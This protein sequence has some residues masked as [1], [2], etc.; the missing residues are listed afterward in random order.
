TLMLYS[1]KVTR[2]EPGIRLA[3]DIH[4]LAHQGRASI[5]KASIQ[6]HCRRT[7]RNLPSGIGTV[8]DASDT[9]DRNFISQSGTQRSN[10]AIRHR[11]Y[12]PATHA[13]RLVPPGGRQA[14]TGH[15]GIGRNHT[16]NAIMPQTGHDP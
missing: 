3:N 6:L 13:P 5:N 10:H 15:G 16:I 12:W 7:S 14:V 9:D 1:I 11:T 4:S 8:H 2:T